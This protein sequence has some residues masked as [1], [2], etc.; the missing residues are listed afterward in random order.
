MRSHLVPAS[1]ATCQGGQRADVGQRTT[2]SNAPTRYREHTQECQ[3]ANVQCVSVPACQRINKQCHAVGKTCQHVIVSTCHRGSVLT[4]TCQ[5]VNVSTCQ[6]MNSSTCQTSTHQRGTMSEAKRAI[7]STSTCQ[8][9]ERLKVSKCQRSNS[10]LNMSVPRLNVYPVPT[11]QRLNMPS[12][13]RLNVSQCVNERIT[14]PKPP[15]K[16]MTHGKIESRTFATADLV[17]I[18]LKRRV[19]FRIEMVAG[20]EGGAS[21]ARAFWPC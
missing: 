20:E 8:H 7:V 1:S 12:C 4:P 11:C 9:C 14:M 17:V 18:R 21:R 15:E 2:Q 6:R 5:R 19:V 13:Q 3:C 16:I 10:E